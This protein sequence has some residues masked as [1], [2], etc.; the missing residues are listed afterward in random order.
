MGW[1]L[2]KMKKFQAKPVLERG[3][4]NKGYDYI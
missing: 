3:Y 2:T 1:L 4:N